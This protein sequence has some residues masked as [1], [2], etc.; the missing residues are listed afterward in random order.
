MDSQSD[1]RFSN[2]RRGEDRLK[3]CGYCSDG[4][5][6]DRT[7]STSHDHIQHPPPT[8]SKR[9]EGLP[10]DHKLFSMPCRVREETS[11]GE[12]AG[13]EDEGV[14]EVVVDVVVELRVGRKLCLRLLLSLPRWQRSTCIC[15]HIRGLVLLILG[16]H[17]ET[18]SGLL[19]SLAFGQSIIF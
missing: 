13:S 1:P 3:I 15:D 7:C 9:R 12:K 10:S 18:S 16:I 19:N 17:A 2:W 6:D 11:H 8:L 4:S 14:G 5:A